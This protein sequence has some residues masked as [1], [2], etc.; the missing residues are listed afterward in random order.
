MRSKLPVP[1][2]CLVSCVLVTSAAHAA[3]VLKLRPAASLYADEKK[4]PLSFPQGVGCGGGKSFVVADSGN[5][6]I[7][8]AESSGALVR[9]LQEIAVP[10]IAYPVR[11]D[12]DPSG[13]LVVLDGKTHRLARVAADGT[14]SKWID[15]SA[16]EGR[17]SV[18]IRSFALA[19]D[20]R[21]LALDAAGRRVV[22]IAPSGSV[23]GGIAF[24]ADLRSGADLAVDARGTVY[25][26]DDVGRRVYSAA[27]GAEALTPLSGSLAEDLDFPGAIA[28]DGGGHLFVADA[29][30]GGVVVLRTDGSFRGRQSGYG[31][32]EGY[33]RYP[34]GLCVDGRGFLIV[35]DRENQRVQ[36][37]SVAQ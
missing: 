3:E 18:A 26:L 21:I 33:V 36:V 27:K 2:A 30:G 10:E 20:G 1:I 6:R 22:R 14:F 7:L 15:V 37:F 19:G 8:R 29:N 28:V 9:V 12:A 25:V 31:W 11:V 16:P 35:A 24:P 13:A 32:K 17:S 34:A 23:E 5:G 4:V